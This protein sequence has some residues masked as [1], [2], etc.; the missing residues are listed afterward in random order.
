MA[1]IKSGQGMPSVV[2]PPHAEPR[3][4]R[5]MERTPALAGQSKLIADR[6]KFLLYKWRLG[7]FWMKLAENSDFLGHILGR[8]DSWDSGAV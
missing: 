3:L 4:T 2:M 5:T 8:V 1:R 7:H 6:R